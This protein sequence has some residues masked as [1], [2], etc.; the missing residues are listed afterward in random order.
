[1]V[2]VAV[3]TLVTQMVMEPVMQKILLPMEKLQ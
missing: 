1:M 2:Y 3:V